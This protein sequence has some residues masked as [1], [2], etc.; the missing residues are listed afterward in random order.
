[1]RVSGFGDR[2]LSFEFWGLGFG[3][4]RREVRSSEFGV[5]VL[6]LPGPS[7]AN[8]D[9]PI[10]Q[11]PFCRLPR[12]VSPHPSSCRS[13]PWLSSFFRFR[14][15][16]L[17]FPHS[18]FSIPRF[19]I[20]FSR[21]SSFRLS[22]SPFRLPLFFLL[23]SRFPNLRLSPSPFRLSAFLPSSFPPDVRRSRPSRP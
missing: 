4:G 15:S 21:I 20:F 5:S 13:C 7:L 2:V 19:P 1:M 9:F 17:R 12:P 8:S 14:L 16:G 11:A 22:P 10:S 6:G 3:P 18:G 23:L